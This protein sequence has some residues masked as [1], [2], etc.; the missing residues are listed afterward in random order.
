MRSG[1]RLHLLFQRLQTAGEEVVGRLD[2]VELL[3]GGEALIHGLQFRAGSKLIVGALDEDFGGGAGLQVIGRTPSRGES[4][5]HQKAG[6]RG[7]TSQ[8]GY[9]ARAEGKAGERVRESGIALA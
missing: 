2:P 7:L 9:D 8:P 4:C 6:A 3:G 1:Y 5:G